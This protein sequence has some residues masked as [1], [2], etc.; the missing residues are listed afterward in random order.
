[1][2]DEK[3]VKNKLDEIKHT[4]YMLDYLSRY[5]NLKSATNHLENFD[6]WYIKF[7]FENSNTFAPM[8]SKYGFVTLQFETMKEMLILLERFVKDFKEDWVDLK[9]HFND[10]LS[11]FDVFY[12]RICY[13]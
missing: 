2:D 9:R 3:Y 6:S 7:N 5:H 12:K 13:K 4:L 1:M 8:Q 11:D 10:C